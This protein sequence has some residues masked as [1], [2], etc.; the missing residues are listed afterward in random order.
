MWAWDKNADR[1]TETPWGKQVNEWLI[2]INPVLIII[3]TL[4]SAASGSNIIDQ[5]QQYSLG[6]TIRQWAKM[7]GDSTVLTIS[8]TN[9]AS[10]TQELANRLHYLSRAGGNGLPGALRWIA[11]VSRLRGGEMDLVPGGHDYDPREPDKHFLAFAVSKHNEMP[12]PL[13]SPARPAIFQMS[14]DGALALVPTTREAFIAYYHEMAGDDD[15]RQRQTKK[16]KADVDPKTS[17]RD[18]EYLQAKNG[19][20]HERTW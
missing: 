15:N 4:A 10:A 16:K 12:A 14:G 3:D 6:I 20:D 7:L 8:H 19:C 18:N 11:G 17:P 13:C 2:A 5:P 1:W 9:Q